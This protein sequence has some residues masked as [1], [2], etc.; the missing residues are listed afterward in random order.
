M[1]WWFR[2]RRLWT[3][4][5]IRLSARDVRPPEIAVGD[6]LEILGQ[7]WAVE[8]EQVSPP[9]PPLRRGAPTAPV[10]LLITLGSPRRQATLRQA[11]PH[12]TQPRRAVDPSSTAPVWLLEDGSGERCI[13]WRDVVHYAVGPAVHRRR[14]VRPSGPSWEV[15]TVRR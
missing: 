15:R 4:N 7:L 5:R 6:R 8:E 12:Q 9:G 13:H 14:S 10:F 1:S 2:L 11:Q 3:Q